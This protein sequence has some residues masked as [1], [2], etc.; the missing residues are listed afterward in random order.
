[1]KFETGHIPWNKGIHLS[2]EAK[3]RLR[4]VNL[5]KHHSE[6]SKQ[7]CRLANLGKKLSIDTKKKMSEYSKRRF[8]DKRNHP[9]YGRRGEKHP[10]WKGDE[11]GYGALHTWVR[12]YK[13]KP[14]LCEMCNNL[15]PRDLSNITGEYLR[16]IDDFQYLCRECHVIYDNQ[17]WGENRSNERD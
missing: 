12:K 10:Q 11:V 2:A 15:P 4:E 7:K 1:M 5:G 8:E 3:Q 16:D 9:M 17:C 14:E 6:E 13:P